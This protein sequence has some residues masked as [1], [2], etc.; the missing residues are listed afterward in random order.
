[1]GFTWAHWAVS[2]GLEIRAD[3]S[4]TW[5]WQ[6][7]IICLYFLG[8]DGLLWIQG[9]NVTA[10]GNELG[11]RPAGSDLLESGPT[12]SRMWHS[13]HSKPRSTCSPTF[14]SYPSSLLLSYQDFTKWICFMKY[15][16][17]CNINSWREKSMLE[18]GYFSFGLICSL[19]QTLPGELWMYSVYKIGKFVYE[20]VNL[21][22]SYIFTSKV[23][24][25][26]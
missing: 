21:H 3:K 8:I 16:K 25:M 6:H 24:G 22:F 9:I 19:F 12:L 20:K 13:W 18:F 5:E 26:E 11:P 17:E 15:F 4:L 1:M 14:T 23:L 2:E 10:W 7:K